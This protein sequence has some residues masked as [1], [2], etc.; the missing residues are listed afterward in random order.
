MMESIFNENKDVYLEEKLSNFNT[1][2][3]SI[4]KKRNDL[5]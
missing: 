4:L 5:I 1:L 2:K 3:N